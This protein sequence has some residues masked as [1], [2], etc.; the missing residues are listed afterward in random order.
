MA[1]IYFTSVGICMLILLAMVIL[2]KESIAKN[3]WVDL[4]KNN[5]NKASPAFMAFLISCIPIFRILIMFC[6]FYMAMNKKENQDNSD[7]DKEE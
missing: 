7:K 5:P 1:K 3:G 2:F 4:T 6:F